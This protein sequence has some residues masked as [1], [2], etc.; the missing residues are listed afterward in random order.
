VRAGCAVRGATQL[1]AVSMMGIM[2]GMLNLAAAAQ[3]GGSSCIAAVPLPDMCCPAVKGSCCCCPSCPRAGMGLC[4]QEHMHSY[5]CLII[6]YHAF[7]GG[8]LQ[9]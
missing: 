9:H 8:L 7:W 2:L 5:V 3:A 1:W 6:S 4:M